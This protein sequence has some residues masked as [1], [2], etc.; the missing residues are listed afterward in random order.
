MAG[1]F[2]AEHYTVDRNTETYSYYGILNLVSYNV[3]YH[4]EHH[5]FPT[6]LWSK[7][8]ELRKIAPEFYETLLQYT[9]W[10]CCIYDYITND[11]MGPFCRVKRLYFTLYKIIIHKAVIG[12]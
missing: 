11:N 10:T 4:N 9:S 8:P 7:L 3:G 5:D 6:I 1:H 12:V 2:I